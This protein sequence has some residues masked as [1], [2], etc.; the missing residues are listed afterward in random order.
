V[1]KII[2]AINVR[3]TGTPGL[4]TACT[5]A[6]ADD[7]GAQADDIVVPVTPDTVRKENRVDAIFDCFYWSD[8]QLI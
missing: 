4:I 1:T 8:D 7:T 3:V 5:R 6:Q 2:C